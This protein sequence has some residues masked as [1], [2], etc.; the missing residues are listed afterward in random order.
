MP[1][2][3]D[4]LRASSEFDRTLFRQVK[5][6]PDFLLVGAWVVEYQYLGSYFA[7]GSLGAAAAELLKLYELRGKWASRKF[8]SAMKS[9]VFWCVVAGMLAASG[10]IAWAINAD[11]KLGP[12]QVVLSG[13][14]A[15]SLIRAPLQ[16]AHANQ[17]ST[18]GEK[19]SRDDF[20][21]ADLLQ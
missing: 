3:L 15:R 4:R 6:Q 12:W 10:F 21:P 7:L 5:R 9:P 13:I 1:V 18:L 2:S 8:V 17:A 16:S 14:G 20:V 19:T 11:T